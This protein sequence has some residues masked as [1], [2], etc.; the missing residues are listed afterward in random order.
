MDLIIPSEPSKEHEARARTEVLRA[1][2]PAVA[3]LMEQHLS[4]RRLWFASDFLPAEEQQ[5]EDQQRVAARIRERA[6]GIPDAVRVSVA[7]GLLTEEG[8]PHFHRMLSRY[9]GDESVWMKWNFLWTAEED[10][11]GAVLRDYAR[12]S[13]LFKFREIEMM[14]H[15][16]NE[17]GFNPDWDKDPYRVFVYTTLQ[18]RATQITHM[19]TGKL[20]GVDEPVLRGILAS[21]AADEA[22]HFSFY[23]NVFKRILEIDPNHALKSALAIL[24]AIDMPGISIPHFR[25]MADVVRRTGI[26]GPWDYKKIVEE[27][28]AFWNIETLTGLNDLGR[29]AQ[30]K[31]MAIPNR[32][33]RVAEY[34]EQRSTAKHF[35]FDFIYG[36]EFAMK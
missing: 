8:L 35:S 36:R 30:E 1:I 24:P 15:A 3:E 22:K 18:E 29:K 13:R 2:E 10:R 5:D 26:Y 27:A 12:E 21:V 9:L 6:R 16:Y 32:L 23:R 11:H 28:I 31:I 33:Q 20:G 34:I 17:A 4:K 7:L 14:Q 25:E 19:N